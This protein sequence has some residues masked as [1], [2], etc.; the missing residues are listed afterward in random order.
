MSPVP[1]EG[2]AASAGRSVEIQGQGQNHEMSRKGRKWALE[3]GGCMVGGPPGLPP[4]LQA[5]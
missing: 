3:A 1:K 4:A 5:A 2:A